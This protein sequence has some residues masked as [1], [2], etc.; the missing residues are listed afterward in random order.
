MSQKPILFPDKMLNVSM[1]WESPSAR[2]MG[3][4]MTGDHV[5]LEKKD[6]LERV[7]C[8]PDGFKTQ[9]PSRPQDLQRHLAYFPGGGTLKMMKDIL[10]PSRVPE[11]HCWNI[12][13]TISHCTDRMGV[14]KEEKITLASWSTHYLRLLILMPY[15]HA[16]KSD[17]DLTVI[18]CHIWATFSLFSFPIHN[19]M[20]HNAIHGGQR[21]STQPTPIDSVSFLTL[22]WTLDT[23]FKPTI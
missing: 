23:I 4:P 6:C 11:F 9:W 14:G 10:A 2:G 12:S 20:Q 7:S 5:V 21:G 19:T 22:F 13:T 3:E 1:W 8:Q 16:H 18:C 15:Y 17:D